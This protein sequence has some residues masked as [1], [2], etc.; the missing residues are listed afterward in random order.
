MAAISMREMKNH[1]RYSPDQKAKCDDDNRFR[2][3]SPH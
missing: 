3:R 1:C 2:H